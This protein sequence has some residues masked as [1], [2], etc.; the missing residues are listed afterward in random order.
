MRLVL[1]VKEHELYNQK[2]LKIYWK[3]LFEIYIFGSKKNKFFLNFTLNLLS[4]YQLPF[5]F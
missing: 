2:P 3:Y 4:S 5:Y 1:P